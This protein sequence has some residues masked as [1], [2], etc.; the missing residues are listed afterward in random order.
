MGVRW[1]TRLH[2]VHGANALRIHTGA[3]KMFLQTV[4]PLYRPL[5][6]LLSFNK[7]IIFRMINNIFCVHTLINISLTE[8]KS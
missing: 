4:G 3:R 8:Y 5:K 2:Q 1:M 7:P 6:I